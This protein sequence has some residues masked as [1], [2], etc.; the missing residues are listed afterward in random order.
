MCREAVSHEA[1]RLQTAGLVSYRRGH[2]LILDRSGLEEKVCECYGVVRA[3]S[4]RLMGQFPR[5]EPRVR[6]GHADATGGLC[7]MSTMGQRLTS[8]SRRNTSDGNRS[9]AVSSSPTAS[10]QG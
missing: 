7:W 2:I 6:Q 10:G 4:E 5:E 3:E 9:R 8:R 1:A